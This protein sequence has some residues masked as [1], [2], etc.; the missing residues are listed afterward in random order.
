MET[1]G[2]P[3]RAYVAPHRVREPRREWARSLE[4]G[5]PPEPHALGDG[6]ELIEL[7]A[8]AQALFEGRDRPPLCARV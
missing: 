1:K 7:V 6:A 5:P 2:P 3:R 4:L 8:A